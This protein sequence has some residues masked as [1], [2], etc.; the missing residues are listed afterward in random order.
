MGSYIDRRRALMYQ[1][2]ISACHRGKG[3]DVN[4]IDVVNVS[5]R[6]KDRE[7]LTQLNL[8]VPAGQLFVLL[9]P[10]GSGKSTL[11]RLISTLYPL[12]VGEIRVFNESVRS[13]P[14][15]VR[16]QIGVVFQHRHL[17][18]KLTRTRTP[19]I[20]LRCLELVVWSLASE[21][22]KSTSNSACRTIRLNES[23][24]SR[25]DGPG[26]SNSPSACSPVRS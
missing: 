17:I 11:F 2:G 21:Q 1:L 26:A 22:R 23:K 20:T 15:A 19:S 4:A 14:H 3:Q 8:Q 9:G 18:R 7:V 13:N 16:N 12:Q 5:H 25:V 10:N 6:Y 24:S